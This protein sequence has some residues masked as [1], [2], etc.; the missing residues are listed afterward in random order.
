MNGYNEFLAHFPA[1]LSQALIEYARDTV[2]LESRYLFVWR[3]GKVQMAYCTHCHAEY[4]LGVGR[5]AYK[6]NEKTACLNCGSECVVKQRGRGRKYLVDHAYIV[7]YEK[8]MIDPHVVVATW[9]YAWRDY[10]GDY[11][12]VETQFEP[13]ARY[14]FE[15]GRGGRM[16]R[17]TWSG[18]WKQMRSVHQLPAG[19]VNWRSI[20]IWCSWESV[21]KAVDGTPLQYSQWEKYRDRYYTLLT[22]FDLAAK[23]PCVEYLTKLGLSGLVTAKLDGEKTYGVVNWR[24][25][26][27]EKV[28]R[29]TRSEVRQL[30]QIASSVRPLTLYSYR[31]WRKLGWDLSP[32]DAH[33]LREFSDRYY[34]QQLEE[35]RA[36]G[37]EIEIAKYLLKQ[38]R[39]SQVYNSATY[40]LVEW[41][42]YLR[43]CE[44]L[45]IPLTEKHVIFPSNLREAHDKM[46]RRVWIKRNENLNQLIQERLAELES[47]SYADEHFL[48]RPARSTSELFEEGKALNHCVGSYAARYAAGQTDL[49][50]MRLV[51]DPD[52]PLCTVEIKNGVVRQA[53][54]YQNRCLNDEEQAF[55]DRFMQH[56][57]RVKWNKLEKQ[58][59][60]RMS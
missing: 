31:F 39:K 7:W 9:Y 52:T 37:T 56:L 58:K 11:H 19:M 36:L 23:Y 47:Y 6:H 22:F 10:S 16:L 24:G 43:N 57:R 28:L 42:D 17:R 15:P 49:F 45:G 48:I 54:G 34:R 51:A 32:M 44:E 18:E 29:M 25:K 20:Y 12:N 1:R 53:R 46:M 2:F 55:L 14:L 50:L 13:R 21:E 8:S 26:S 35:L 38:I 30:Q 60:R 4:Q 41:R 5:A 3:V 33:V 40:A 59:I 27:L